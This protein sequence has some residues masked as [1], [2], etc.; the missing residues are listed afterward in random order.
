[1]EKVEKSKFDFV[2]R[3][4]SLALD[5][6]QHHQLEAVQRE[7]LQIHIQSITADNGLLVGWMD[8]PENASIIDSKEQQ[9][10][11]YDRFDLKQSINI[12]CTIVTF[13]K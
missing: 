5:T 2:Q 8:Y 1:L 11:Y 3:I 13:I 6:F 9:S 12:N 7:Q 10:D 4:F